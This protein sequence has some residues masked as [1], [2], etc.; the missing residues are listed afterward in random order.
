MSVI[1]SS[2]Y[3]FDVKRVA[4]VIPNLNQLKNKKY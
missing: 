2:E 4:D 1:Y 3:W